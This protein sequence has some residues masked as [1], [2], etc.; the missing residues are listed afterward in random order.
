[1][2][3]DVKVPPYLQDKPFL[4]LSSLKTSLVESADLDLTESDR[5]EDAPMYSRDVINDFPKDIK[6]DM[7]DSQLKACESMLTKEIAIVQGPPGTGKTFVSVSA[8]KVMVENLGPDDPPIIVTAQTNHALDQL[9]NHIM[10]FE[11]RIVRLGGRS[12]RSNKEIRLRTLYELRKANPFP[13]GSAGMK[14]AGMDHNAVCEEILE[15]LQPLLSNRVLT[16][17][18]LVK[19]GLITDCQRTSLNASDWEE[20]E[21]AATVDIVDWLTN[22]QLM[23]IA[24]APVVNLG[25]PLEESD[26]EFEQLLELEMMTE[27]GGLN[28]HEEEEATGLGG[29]WVPF[30]R[31]FTGRHD[32]VISERKIKKLLLT[33]KDLYKI[34]AATRGEVYRY[35]E[36]HTDASMLRVL[37]QKLRKYDAF[38]AD[39]SVTRSRNNIKL[40]QHLDIKVIGC[41]TTGLSKYRGILS[42]LQPR[43]LLIEEAAETLEGKIIGGMFESLEQ[44][45]LV[46]D[47]QQLQASCTVRALEDEP[48][49][50]K[51]SMFER[52]I[53]NAMPFVMLNKQRRMIPDVRRLLCIEPKPFYDN[54]QDHAS[55]LVRVNRPPVPGMGGLDTYFFHHTWPEASN[56]DCSKYNADEAEMIAG[57]FNYLVQNGTEASK[58]TVL[59]FYNGQRKTILR[60]LKKH[61]SLGGNT[62][63]KVF[64]VDSYQ[65]EENDIIL[66]SLVRSNQNFGVGFLDNKN[67]LVVALSRARRG[68]YVFGNAVT[69]TYAESNDDFIDRD[70]MWDSLIMF[71]KDQRRFDFEKGLPITCARHGTRTNIMEAQNW[72]FNAGGCSKLCGAVLSCGHT[73]PH[74]CKSIP[75]SVRCR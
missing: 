30:K 59:T 20:D 42:A 24:G 68:L 7:D 12:D 15:T 25:L 11:S 8:L 71:M 21:E 18:T 28:E 37:H 65:G 27:A 4:N 3:P 75:S 29:L 73:C 41:T 2:I 17:E 66:L 38:V 1:M 22:N 19:E 53:N 72:M 63:F 52:L 61:P 45:I 36:Q 5:L 39:Y 44:L 35:F 43:T 56:T 49:Y 55:V 54:L 64:T 74:S 32:S 57:F 51:V 14:M 16:A 40:M 47:H 70:P 26:I 13:G 50:L 10:H 23:P 60:E 9:L 58:I 31:T 46:G 34:P 67:R 69:L 6:C 33:C 48:Y 62:Y